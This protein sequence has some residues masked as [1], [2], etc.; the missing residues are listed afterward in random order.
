MRIKSYFAPSVQS[1]ISIARKEFGDNVTLV[2]SHA[3]SLES[4]HLGEYEVVFA[5]EQAAQDVAEEPKESA[6]ETAAAPAATFEDVL[7]QAIATPSSTRENAADNLQQVH[8]LLVEMG[9][10][11]AMVRA[12]MTMIGRSVS[13]PVPALDLPPLETPQTEDPESAAAEAQAEEP[14]PAVADGT[15]LTPAEMAFFLSVSVGA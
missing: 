13:L 5:V 14:T 4:R 12:L 8:S 1:A 10:D 3:A 2:T 7:Q 15:Q 11:A 9:I 6:P